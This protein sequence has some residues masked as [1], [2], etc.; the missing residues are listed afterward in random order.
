MPH[1]HDEAAADAG[2]SGNALLQQPQLRSYRKIHS[3]YKD[4]AFLA[5]IGDMF[6]QQGEWKIYGI[7]GACSSGLFSSGCCC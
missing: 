2:R 6:L 5:I 7:G 3:I 4:M 1:I